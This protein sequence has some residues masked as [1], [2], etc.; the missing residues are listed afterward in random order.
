MKYFKIITPLLILLFI[1]LGNLSTPTKHRE[2]EFLMD[3]VV[4]VTAYGNGSKSA[5]QKVFLRLRELDAKFNA[6]SDKSELA[7][8]N[9]SSENTPVSVNKEHTYSASGTVGLVYVL[10]PFF[11]NFLLES[12]SIE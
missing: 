11:P 2:T 8:I 9:A 5:V 10:P 6:H 1:L 12:I 4:T 3:T 7:K